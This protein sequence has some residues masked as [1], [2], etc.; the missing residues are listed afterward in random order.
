LGDLKGI[1]T[2]IKLYDSSSKLVFKK[3]SSATLLIDVS[4][5]AKGSYTLEL[6]TSDKVLSS[7]VIIE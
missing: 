2:T 3:Q 7:Q 5:Y 1:N 4:A 6:Y